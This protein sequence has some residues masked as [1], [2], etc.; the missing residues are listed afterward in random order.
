MRLAHEVNRPYIPP[1]LPERIWMQ[2]G[3]ANSCLFTRSH[4]SF[5]SLDNISFR[6]PVNI[7]SILRLESQILNTG[8]L[9]EFPAAVVRGSLSLFLRAIH[10]FA[11]MPRHGNAARSGPSKRR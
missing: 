6:K 3:F 11:L 8:H 1:Q 9:G 7:G 2:L 4:V 10:V 5:L